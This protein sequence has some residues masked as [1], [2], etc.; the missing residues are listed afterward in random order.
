MADL[1]E[2]VV[3]DATVV[4]EAEAL[5]EVLDAAAEAPK[6]QRKPRMTEEEKAAKAAAKAEKAAA[7]V[8]TP[9]VSTCIKA[10]ARVYNMTDIVTLVVEGNPKSGE[11]AERFKGYVSGQTVAEALAAGLKRGDI[12][13]DVGH[14]FIEVAPAPAPAA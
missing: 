8:K 4:E 13:W 5:V 6:R 2:E 12:V 14:G 11:S 3:A 7:K 10:G 9:R 1:V